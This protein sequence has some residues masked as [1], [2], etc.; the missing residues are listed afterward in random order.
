MESH[1]HHAR[2][3]SPRRWFMDRPPTEVRARPGEGVRILE[4]TSRAFDPG[5]RVPKDHVR[6]GGNASPSV[7][8]KPAPEGTQAFALIC[9]DPDAP[10][11]QPFVHWIIYNIPAQVR[12]MPLMTLPEGIRK[13]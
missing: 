7:D 12:G 8:W 11:S 1:F 5:Q 13:G 3:S 9:E 2:F 4:M 6:D 10:A